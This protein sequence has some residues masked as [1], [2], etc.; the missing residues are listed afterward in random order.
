VAEAEVG[1]AG[2]GE[3]GRRTPA[4]LVFVLNDGTRDALGG[5]RTISTV[6]WQRAMR[7]QRLLRVYWG[8]IDQDVSIAL[9]Q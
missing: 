9:K 1:N 2:L 7:V 8:V 3:F 5:A 4:A 6:S